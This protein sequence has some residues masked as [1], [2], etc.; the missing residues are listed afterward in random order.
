[1]HIH[2]RREVILFSGCA[3]DAD[4]TRVID[5]HPEPTHV[6]Q[7]VLVFSSV[8]R[9]LGRGA[10]RV[11]FSV[12]PFRSQS[13]SALIASRSIN[14]SIYR[15]SVSRHGESPILLGGVGCGP[16][17]NARWDDLYG[18]TVGSGPLEVERIPGPAARAQTPTSTPLPRSSG[19]QENANS[20]VMLA[21]L[22]APAINPSRWAH[23]NPS[24]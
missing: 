15:R 16:H 13:Q 14:R 9:I 21:L 8:A 19:R 2:S 7:D 10:R 23:Q 17:W 6:R 24:C 22:M 18:H 12:Y 11:W 3:I 20:S 4:A 5:Y 1:M